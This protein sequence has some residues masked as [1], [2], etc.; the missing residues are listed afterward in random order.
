[1][2][3]VKAK[4]NFTKEIEA[5]VKKLYEKLDEKISQLNGMEIS[6]ADKA[7][8][9]PSIKKRIGK[10]EKCATVVQT[11]LPAGTRKGFKKDADKI[12]TDIENL[13]NLLKR[14]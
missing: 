9:I 5:C 11:P 3:F 12:E 10:L 13:E 7:Y 2:G 1:M 8:W 14:R 4:E 6:E